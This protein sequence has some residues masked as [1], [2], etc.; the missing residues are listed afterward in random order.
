LWEPLKRNGLVQTPKEYSYHL[1]HNAPAS[2]LQETPYSNGVKRAFSAALALDDE[3]KN[4]RVVFKSET[5]AGLGF[6]LFES[7]LEINDKWLS[8]RDR[9]RRTPCWLSRQLRD[10]PDMDHFSCCHVI[11]DL[12]RIVVGE[13]KNNSNS[14]ES[15]RLKS[16]DFLYQQVCE[17][18]RKMPILVTARPGT[19]SGE[20]DVF[21]TDSEGV[22]L[23]RVYGVDPQCKVTLHLEST[24]SSKRSQLLAP[25][26]PLLLYINFM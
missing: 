4:L 17:S 5:K 18:L 3:T 26:K 15:D 11:T 21:W 20:I 8:F 16:Y 24:C 13:L 9:H 14:K 19:L 22:I 6:I 12:Y 7:T 2:E 25:G 1:L 23:S 10:N